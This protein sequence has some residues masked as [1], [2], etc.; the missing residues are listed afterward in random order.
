MD[1]DAVEQLAGLEQDIPERERLTEW[2]GD[3][4][5]YEPKPG[6]AQEDIY[7][8]IKELTEKRG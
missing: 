5:I 1:M 3:Y 2:F 6:V 8:R 7:T 4:G